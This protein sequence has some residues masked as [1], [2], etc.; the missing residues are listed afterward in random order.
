MK[1]T[2]FEKVK[3][4]FERL[5]FHGKKFVDDIDDVLKEIENLE[6]T[7]AIICRTNKEVYAVTGYLKENDIEFS[8]S[9]DVK[10]QKIIDCAIS[11]S[12]MLGLLASYLSSNKY[13]EYIRLSA[14]TLR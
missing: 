7:S 3:Y 6:G 8:T 1:S 13:G 5:L 11:D 10:I 12:Y 9:K 4:L 2:L 14:H